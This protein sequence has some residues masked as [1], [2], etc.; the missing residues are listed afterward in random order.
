MLTLLA[1]AVAHAATP[2]VLGVG[3]A[4][5]VVLIVGRG[6]EERAARCDDLNGDGLWACPPQDLPTRPEVLGLLL[7]GA[8]L[9][10]VTGVNLGEAPETVVVERVGELLRVDTSPPP[11]RPATAAARQGSSALLVEVQGAASPRLTATG[12]QSRVELS[13]DDGGEF[14]DRIANDG[15]WSCAGVSPEG[16]LHLSLRGAGGGAR[17]LGTLR[18]PPEQG[19]RQVRVDANGAAVATWPILS[20]N[21]AG[22][23]RDE[24]PR[25]EDA[26]QAHAPPPQDGGPHRGGTP[27]GGAPSGGSTA[28][29]SMWISALGAVGLGL[30][31]W[32]VAAGRRRPVPHAQLVPLPPI[33]SGGPAGSAVYRVPAGRASEA[34]AWI[35]SRAARVRPVLMVGVSAPTSVEGPVWVARSR[36]ADDVAEAASAIAARATCPPLIIATPGAITYAGAVG[37]APESALLRALPEGAILALLHEDGLIPVSLPEITLNVFEGQ[38]RAR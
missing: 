3:D 19:L 29:T 35:A 11:P 22:G 10:S 18:W 28:P 23:R 21:A 8:T 6:V 20:R 12:E 37:P 30:L 33:L 25:R 16:D 13:C 36:D 38:W 17:E 15:T 27:P 5:S 26:G 34:A 24:T 14:P 7:D 1:I 2:Q 32:R 9:R 31:A 4:R